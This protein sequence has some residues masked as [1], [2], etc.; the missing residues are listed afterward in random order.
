MTN[1]GMVNRVALNLVATFCSLAGTLWADVQVISETSQGG[2]HFRFQTLPSP[3]VDDAGARGK[4]K[5]VAGRADANSGAI[6]KLFDGG[7]P[8]SEDQPSQNFFFAAGTEGGLIAVDLEQSLDLCEIVTYSWHSE[9]RAPQ[10]YSIYAATGVEK[11]FVFPESAESVSKTPGWK[12]IADVDARTANREG[13][14]HVA[15]VFRPAGPL[16]T[17]RHL[18]FAFHATEPGDS[19][20]NTF[21]SEI[22]VIVDD[23]KALQRIVVPELREIKFSTVD[24]TF[25]FTVD[26][27]QALELEEWTETEL[28][29]V[30]EEWYPRI[31][32]LLPGEGFEAARHVRFQYLRDVEMKG[33][34]AYASGS[35]ISMN[36][37]WFRGQLNGEA[38]GAV[39]HEMVHVVQSYPR[40]SRSARGL[41]RP[42]GWVIE[43]VPDYIRWFLYEPQAEG[44]RLS[45]QFLK[46][47]KHDA[48]YRISAN[49]IDWVIR[50]YPLEGKLLERLNTAARHGKYSSDFWKELT[51]KS[52]DQLEAAW[53]SGL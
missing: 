28:S 37:E 53:R 3:A 26:V 23:A 10:V 1:T 43:G 40:G 5:I 31:V 51:G 19:F 41:A 18:I 49:F 44:A 45:P 42:P 46:N 21:L 47:A 22:D 36:A 33:T 14:Q 29:P 27:T 20:S 15:K 38:R 2:N 50:K 9:N 34:P 48:S 52:E 11:G 25:H 17:F 7:V 39:V 4:W 12:R 16:G 8:T 32:A 35:T 30:I 6:E 24:E 13:G